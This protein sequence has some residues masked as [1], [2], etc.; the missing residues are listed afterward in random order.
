MGLVFLCGGAGL[1]KVF[2]Y[3]RCPFW[4]LSVYHVLTNINGMGFGLG[5]LAAFFF[6]RRRA[7]PARGERAPGLAGGLNLAALALLCFAKGPVA[8]VAVLAFFCAAL[9]R[10]PG[11]GRGGMRLRAATLAWA[12]ML[13]AGFS[14][15]YAAFFSAGA[16]TSIHFSVFGTLEKSY[17]TNFIALIRA[18]WPAL[19]A[20]R[21]L[22]SCWRRPCAMRR[23][24][25]RFALLAACAMLCASSA[26]RAK[27]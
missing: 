23:L 15:L 12:L 21:R 16:G 11:A 26:C 9:V 7:V 19:L 18:K 20:R 25:C 6:H 3:G 5:L 13:L 4:N 10:L 17:F 14:A 24:P 27:G 22:C 1:W 8:G 2:E